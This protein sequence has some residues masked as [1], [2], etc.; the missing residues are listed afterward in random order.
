MEMRHKDIQNGRHVRGKRL[1]RTNNW[2]EDAHRQLAKTGTSAP[3]GEKV[4]SEVAVSVFRGSPLKLWS[5]SK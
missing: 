2:T 5:H 1:D 4:G 3:A